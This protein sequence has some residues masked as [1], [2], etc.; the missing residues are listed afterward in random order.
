MQCSFA[1]VLKLSRGDEVSVNEK[2]TDVSD[3]WAHKHA[4]P[5]CQPFTYKNLICYDLSYFLNKHTYIYG[6]N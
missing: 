6:M 4:T 1:D 3:K 5:L 2:K